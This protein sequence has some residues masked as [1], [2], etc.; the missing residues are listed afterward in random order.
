MGSG[1]IPR[2]GTDSK[3]STQPHSTNGFTLDG[4]RVLLVEMPSFDDTRKSDA[5]VLKMIAASLATT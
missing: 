5:D 2:I 1:S 3:P 4:Q